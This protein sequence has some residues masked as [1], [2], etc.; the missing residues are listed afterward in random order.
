MPP[1]GAK[2][3]LYGG[4]TE[5]QLTANPALVGKLGGPAAA[6]WAARRPT[7]P[8]TKPGPAVPTAPA[9]SKPGAE[10]YGGYTVDQ[11]TANPGLVAKLGPHAARR[12]AARKPVAAPPPSTPTPPP[13]AP[14]PPTPG[15][16]V[17]GTPNAPGAGPMPGPPAGGM[18]PGGGYGPGDPPA[19]PWG[20]MPAGGPLAPGVAN[21][22]EDPMMM[23]LSAVPAMRLNT[24][25]QLSDAMAQAGMGGNR[26]GTSAQRTAG[27]IG[28]ESAM[29][30]NAL[31]SN[32]LSNYANNQENRALQ[33]TGQAT[34]LGGMLDQMA[35]SRVAL[36]FQVGGYEQGRQDDFS[37][38]AFDDWSANR[39]GWMGPL[40]QAA[41]S[42]GAGSPGSP[43]QIIPITEGGK[44]GTADWLA[45]LAGMF[46]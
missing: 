6:R 1:V 18:P 27:Q 39:L 29:Q 45:L 8:A 22:F 42:Q 41:M 31:M 21:E 30:E 11:L 3:V 17:G 35:Q 19:S 24:Q 44:E 26:W 36:P 12:W 9:P 2:P 34:N 15:P 23:F 7:E 20:G 25:K 38:M 37:K 40:L 33:A 16:P 13:A 10:L 14:A 32:L 4:Y 28:A 43:G 5:Q 46:S